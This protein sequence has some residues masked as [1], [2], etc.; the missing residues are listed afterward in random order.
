M[1]ARE[2]CAACDWCL[3]ELEPVADSTVVARKILSCVARV[4]QMWGTAH[5]TD[6]LIGKPTEKVITAGHQTLSTFGLLREVEEM[7]SGK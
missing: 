3:K 5:V 1:Y 4:K 7:I 6:V 2:N